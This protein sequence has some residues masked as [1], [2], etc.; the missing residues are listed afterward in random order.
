LVGALGGR[1][2]RDWAAVGDR[3]TASRSAR[4]GHQFTITNA[5]M[6]WMFPW[7]PSVATAEAPLYR[8]SAL[9]DAGSALESAVRAVQHGPATRP[10][11]GPS[12]PTP[13]NSP[14][15]ATFPWRVLI[16]SP[17]VAKGPRRRVP[18]APRLSLAT[19]YPS[20][21]RDER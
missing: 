1:A 10:L 20:S 16:Q 13:L 8:G 9:V 21:L 4:M 12:S 11:A 7:I 2:G 15:N 5:M 3:R 6:P 19:F 14:G 17:I 18:D